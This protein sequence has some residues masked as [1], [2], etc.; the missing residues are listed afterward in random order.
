MIR[1]KPKKEFVESLSRELKAFRT[2]LLFVESSHDIA[3]LLYQ[4]DTL[5]FNLSKYT[6]K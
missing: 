6:K 1:K 5:L 3:T 2:S 4:I